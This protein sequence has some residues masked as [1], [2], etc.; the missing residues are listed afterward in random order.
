MTDLRILVQTLTHNKETGERFTVKVFEQPNE[1]IEAF[2]SK[3]CYV[4]SADKFY[5]LG[6]QVALGEGRDFFKSL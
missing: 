2:K 3:T 5:L 1:L 6:I 4:V